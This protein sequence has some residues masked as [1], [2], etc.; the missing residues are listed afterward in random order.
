MCCEQLYTSGVS[1]DN[2]MASV[3]HR[4]KLKVLYR[5]QGLSANIRYGKRIRDTYNKL[6]Y[7]LL[8]IFVKM[9]LENEVIYVGIPDMAVQHKD[10]GNYSTCL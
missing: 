9:V 7:S 1:C 10:M 2:L 3:I 6:I 8:T 5:N 4:S